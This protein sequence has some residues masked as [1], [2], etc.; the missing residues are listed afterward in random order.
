MTGGLIWRAVDDN[1]LSN[2][3]EALTA[4]LAEQPTQGLA[5]IKQA[6]AQSARNIAEREIN[7]IAGKHDKRT[8]VFPFYLRTEEDPTHS[9]PAGGAP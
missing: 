1:R 6:L 2:E 8:L 3:A 9:P 7:V 5:L 4:R